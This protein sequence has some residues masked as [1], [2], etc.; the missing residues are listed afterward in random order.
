MGVVDADKE[1]APA[2]VDVVLPVGF[3]GLLGVNIDDLAY[4][5][6]TVE[7]PVQGFGGLSNFCRFADR[8]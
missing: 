4:L 6:M 8:T 5:E 2:L 3:A 7:A 1:C